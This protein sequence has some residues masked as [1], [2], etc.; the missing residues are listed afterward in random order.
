VSATDYLL[1]NRNAGVLRLGTVA[2]ALAVAF[3]WT[4][5]CAPAAA[6]DDSEQ[7]PIAG[8]ATVTDGDGLEI[9]G[10][11]IRLYGIDAPEVEQYCT[12]KDGTRWHCGQYSTVALDRLVA[13][14][15]V[16]CDVRTLD[17]YARWVAVCKVG[18]VD[19]G[20]YQVSEGWAVAY[21]RY[22]KAYVDDENA[23]RRKD[24]GM[25]AGK[26]EMPW[27][28]RSGTRGR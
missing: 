23:A 5:V 26:F 4:A 2:F 17:S 11:R 1:A 27:D 13:G 8:L 25:W 19:L 9:D 15:K 16:I 20:Q 3:A 7:E 28:W 18:K 22:S 21:R 24:R 14:K 10:E 6:A 12:R